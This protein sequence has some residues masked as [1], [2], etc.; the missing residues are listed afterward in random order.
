MYLSF[1]NKA[2]W[3]SLHLKISLEDWNMAEELKLT[4]TTE[5]LLQE[6]GVQPHLWM[7]VNPSLACPIPRSPGVD[8]AGS[9]SLVASAASATETSPPNTSWDCTDP[10]CSEED[11]LSPSSEAGKLTGD[12]D[13]SRADIP[14]SQEMPETPELKAMPTPWKSTV[15]RPQSVKLKHP[16]QTS[17]KIKG[18]WPRPPLNYC[19]LIALALCNSTSGSLTVQQIYQ[20]I[21]QQFPFFQTAPEAWKNTIRH[22]L[23]FSSCFEKTTGFACGEG[24]RKSCL[25]KL[26]PEG[27]RKFQEEAQALPKEGLDLVCQSMSEP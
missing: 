6:P 20:F 4:V 12:E 1:Q 5:D 8:P 7:W 3:E 11:V 23:C 13:A 19:V 16:G 17:A 14:V 25:W 15:L 2:F 18:G 22:K 10:D 27:C 9:N 21:R 24:H 26:T